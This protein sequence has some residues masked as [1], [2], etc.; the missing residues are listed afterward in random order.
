[1][2]LDSLEKKIEG[3]KEDLLKMGSLLQEQIYNADLALFNKDMD[4]ARE[5]I[6]KEDIIDEMHGDIEEKALLLIA[7]K[8]PMAK[9][10][11]FIA[12]ALRFIIDM[13]RMADHAE[14]IAKIAIRLY[15]EPYMKPLIDIPKMAKLA[16]DMVQIAMQSF[17]AGD[18]AL[19]MSLVPMENEVDALYTTVYNDLV[20]FM[21]RD[22]STIAQ[23]TSLLL[24]AGHLERIAD[25][26]TN[27]GEMVVYLIEGRRI[28][29]NVIA[30]A[31]RGAGNDGED[32]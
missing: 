28:D 9:D 14:G 15:D 10:L 30:R 31:Y 2:F 18:V 32:K 26:S 27:M 7:L 20:A 22:P 5:V 11:R 24:V 4:L 19:A 25:R 21:T 17:I 8:Q 6:R 12:T 16:Q 13:E 1:M 3:L 29:M 23:A